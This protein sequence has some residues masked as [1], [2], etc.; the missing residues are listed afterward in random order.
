[1]EDQ[2]PLIPNYHVGRVLSDTG[3]FAIVYW[4][5]DLRT[6]R[7]VAIKQPRRA[8]PAMLSALEQEAEMYL[9]LSQNNK[10]IT[11]LKDF[12]KLQGQDYLVMEYVEGTTLDVY[13]KKRGGYLH[14][15]EAIP[16]FLQ[17]LDGVGYIH[18]N[19]IVHKD[20]KPGNIMVRN[21]M[22]IK[23]LDMGISAKLKDVDNN[24]RAVGTPA[25]MPPEQF[26]REPCGPYTDI[27]ALG[28]TLFSVLTGRL[29]FSGRTTTDIWNQI[30][31]G[32]IPEAHDV[33]PYVNP[34]FQP[35]LNKALQPEPW[36]RYQTCE[37]MAKAIKAIHI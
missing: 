15:E 12:I 13:Q 19:H 28:V 31:A 18:R 4:G 20:I 35:I 2:L 33:N 3:G 1:M 11:K 7:A 27:F 25:F 6:G 17:I 14:D 26:K 34:R 5:F 8:N 10:H 29:P 23:L 30:Q 32:A 22:V 16:L 24:P 9:Y 36:E 37:E 21:D